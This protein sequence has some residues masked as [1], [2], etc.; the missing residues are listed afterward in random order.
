MQCDPKAH[1]Q[2]MYIIYTHTLLYAHILHT[3]RTY[4]TYIHYIHTLYAYTRF[5]N[6]DTHFP[7][8]SY[9]NTQIE[10]RL[11]VR[12]Q[13]IDDRVVVPW[14][15]LFWISF[16][17]FDI[18]LSLILSS[19]FLSSSFLSLPFSICFVSFRSLCCP[20]RR[21]FLSSFLVAFLSTCLPFYSPPSAL[22]V[23]FAFPASR[24]FLSRGFSR[25]IR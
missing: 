9:S 16:L 24:V 21:L 25:P 6:P 18:R 1:I 3:E 10:F 17:R 7:K 11:I 5:D 20:P 12:T 8:W 15:C 4:V 23:S 13:C 22:P 2:D 14:A 19:S